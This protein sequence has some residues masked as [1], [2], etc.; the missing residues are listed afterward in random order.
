MNV[1]DDDRGATPLAG[2]PRELPPPAGLEERV[3]ARLAE[4]RL[5]ARRSTRSW[6]LPLAAA[7][8]GLAGG[9]LLRG[10]PVPASARSDASLYLLLLSGEPRTERSEPELVSIY[11]AWGS[12]L[13]A[14]GQLAGSQKLKHE[15]IVLADG[16]EG[17]AS[18]LE[19]GSET[20]SG[21]F[22]V[23]ALSLAEAETIARSCPHARFGGRV[24]V[25][26]IDPV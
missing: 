2:L 7:L 4:K 23:R 12:D 17:P 13:A 19:I 11:K 18:A 15:G 3:V 25:R 1:H 22:L 21:F 24:T 16:S 8:A 26:P 14:R 5:L 10:A 9:W 20:P 6:L